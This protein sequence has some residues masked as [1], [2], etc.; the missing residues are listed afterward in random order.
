MTRRCCKA[1]PYCISSLSV[2]LRFAAAACLP[3]AV[4]VR[5]PRPSMPSVRLRMHTSPPSR[6]RPFAETSSVLS[7]FKPSSMARLTTNNHAEVC[8]LSRRDN[9]STPIRCIT[10]RH[11]L[12]PLPTSAGSHLRL[13]DPCLDSC[14]SREAY[15][16]T[17]FR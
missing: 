15:R 9:V 16:L 4:P 10:P 3:S 6:L 12:S 5:V 2:P 14:L 13:T 7:P 8:T 1:F 11:S 17:Q